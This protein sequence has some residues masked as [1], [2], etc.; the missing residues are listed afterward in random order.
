MSGCGGHLIYP[1]RKVYKIINQNIVDDNMEFHSQKLSKPNSRWNFI[2]CNKH[3]D[4]ILVS[5][6]ITYVRLGKPPDWDY[7]FLDKFLFFDR[8]LVPHFGVTS[9][10]NQPICNY[11]LKT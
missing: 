6:I 2:T 3:N 5:T 7:Y 1:I 10:I 9:T 11:I 8:S 4:D